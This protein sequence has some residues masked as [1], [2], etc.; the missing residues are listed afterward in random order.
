MPK[1]KNRSRVEILGDILSVAKGGAKKT[2][3]MYKSNLSFAQ[4]HLYLTFLL[5]KE[6]IDER[7]EDETRIYFTTMRGL[8]FLRHYDELNELTSEVSEPAPEIIESGQPV[9]PLS[10]PAVSR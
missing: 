9:Q 7:I 10:G 3:L 1:S 5:Q 2:H 6:L 8:E 4:L